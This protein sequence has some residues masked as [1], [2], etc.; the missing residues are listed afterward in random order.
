MLWVEGHSWREQ[1]CCCRWSYA[2][3]KPFA[4]AEVSFVAVTLLI[5]PSSF[6]VAVVQ[7]VAL[8]ADRFLAWS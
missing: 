8:V 7:L 6:V 5:A 3:A 1:S 4:A 2:P